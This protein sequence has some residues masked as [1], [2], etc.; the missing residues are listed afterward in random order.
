[1]SCLCQILWAKESKNGERRLQQGGSDVNEDRRGTKVERGQK[2]TLSH[3]LSKIV[4]RRVAEQ[5][6]KE[7]RGEK[8]D[9][10]EHN[11]ACPAHTH[12]VPPKLAPSLS[13]MVRKPPPEKRRNGGSG[14]VDETG[15]LP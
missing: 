2:R 8:C 10:L 6:C 9:P 3:G 1:M 11:T 4:V 7:D 14:P 5:E 12:F 13:S 15:S